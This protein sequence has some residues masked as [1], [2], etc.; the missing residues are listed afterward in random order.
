M[1][2]KGVDGEGASILS[3]TKALPVKR[4]GLIVV[5]VIMVLPAAMLIQ[6]LITNP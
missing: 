3:R 6:G 1:A 5:V 2:K 4:P